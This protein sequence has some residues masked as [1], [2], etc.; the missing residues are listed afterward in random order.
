V[1]TA[2]SRHGDWAEE[3]LAIQADGKIVA[4]GVAGARGANPTFA[5]A[6]HNGD[7]TLDATFGGDGKVRTDFSRRS[8]DAIGLVIQA[9]GRI[10]AAG[11]AGESDEGGGNSKFALARYLP[12]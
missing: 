6:R 3:G 2:F 8:D 9:D 4:A 1:I 10:V 5:L 12:V 7:G 11:D